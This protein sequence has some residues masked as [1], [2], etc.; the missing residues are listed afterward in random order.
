MLVWTMGLA[1]D[2]LGAAL[3]TGTSM[4]LVTVTVEAGSV[5]V[6][7]MKP[8]AALVDDVAALICAGAYVTDE[9]AVD[10]AVAPPAAPVS[11][12]GFVGLMRNCVESWS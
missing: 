1:L 12:G 5:T 11:S 9:A 6:T 8:P 4:V 2:C 7:V 3:A 10:V